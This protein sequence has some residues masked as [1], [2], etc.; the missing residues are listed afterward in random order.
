ERWWWRFQQRAYPLEDIP[1]GALFRAFEQIRQADA[2]ASSRASTLRAQASRWVGVGPAPVQGG[3]IGTT[4]NTRPM[5]G[6]VNAIA[7]DPSDSRHWLVGADG[8][9]IWETKDEGATWAARTDAQV[10]LSM[11]AIA[12]APSDPRTVYAMT[13]SELFS[14]FAYAG[15]GLLK[16][17][18]GG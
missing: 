3:Q 10:S 8:G 15:A 13:G 7:V 12:F 1:E 18:D 11:G 6:R 5:S 17:T 9:G 4:G 2:E 14:G 16:S